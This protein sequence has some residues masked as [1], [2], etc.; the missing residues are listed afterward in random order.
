MTWLDGYVTTVW[1]SDQPL[2]V[3]EQ[4]TVTIEHC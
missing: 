3:T 4:D 2:I 1:H